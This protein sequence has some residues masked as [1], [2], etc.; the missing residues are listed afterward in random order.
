MLGKPK[1]LEP[2]AWTFVAW[3]FAV[4]GLT[5][6][7]FVTGLIGLEFG[8]IRPDSI[9]VWLPAGVG[10]AAL[11]VLGYRTWPGIFLGSLLISL[12]ASDKAIILFDEIS[13]NKIS[14]IPSVLWQFIIVSPLSSLG[15]AAVYTTGLLVGAVVML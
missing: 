2:A 7:Y 15:L 3:L 13:A 14:Q 5:L 6:V 9:P 10:L 11:I 4:I 1:S 8:V 12:V